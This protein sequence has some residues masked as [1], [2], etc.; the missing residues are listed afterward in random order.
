MQPHNSIDQ[1]N[2]DGNEVNPAGLFGQNHFREGK[3]SHQ[4]EKDTP[5]SVSDSPSPTG[6]DD[7]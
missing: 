2:G 5:K 3:D 6:A 7:R 1:N 4:S